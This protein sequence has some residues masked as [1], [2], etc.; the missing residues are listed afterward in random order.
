MRIPKHLSPSSHG[1]WESDREDFYIKYLASK[2]PIRKPQTEPMAVGSAFD[3]YVKASLHAD[4]FG[5]GADPVYALDALMED[6]V[7]KEVRDWARTAGRH[8]FNCYRYTGAY[9]ELLKDLQAAPEAPQFEFTVTGAP[10]GVPLRGK[11]DC[12]YIHESGAHVMLDWKVSGYC[13][14][15]TTSPKKL[16]AMVRDGQDMAKPSQNNGNPHKG[17]KPQFFKGLTIGSHFLE[18]ACP[19]WADQLAIYGWM[20]GEPVGTEDMV[21]RIDQIATKPGPSVPLLRVA[22]QR[23]RISAGWQ[24]KLKARLEDAWK[25]ILSGHIFPDMTREENDLRCETLDMLVEDMR[26]DDDPIWQ[27]LKGGYRR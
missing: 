8:V 19:D 17:Y 22:N 18:E 26:E 11:P 14:Q 20:L 10:F 15:R 27:D 13:G 4:L 5:Q 25:T 16:Y 6:Q 23:A 12:R 9:D 1:T 3:A 7:D 21:A 24:Q 2:R